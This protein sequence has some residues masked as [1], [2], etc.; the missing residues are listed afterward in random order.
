MIRYLCGVEN[1]LRLV[2]ARPFVV[3]SGKDSLRI[4]RLRQIAVADLLHGFTDVLHVVLGEV[5]GV[6]PGIRQHLV[7]FI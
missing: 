1:A 6:C 5:A 4:L 3:F 7:L 2:E